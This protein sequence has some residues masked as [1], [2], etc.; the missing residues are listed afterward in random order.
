M[1]DT[2]ISV[3]GISDLVLA[4]WEIS[5]FLP[6]HPCQHDSLKHKSYNSLLK[7]LQWFPILIVIKFK[8]F[9]IVYMSC[10]PPTSPPSYPTSH[11]F[12]HYALTPLFILLLEYLNL[13]SDSGTLH[14]LFL[15]FSWHALPTCVI[16][17]QSFFIQTSAQ[18]F[19]PPKGCLL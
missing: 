15:L 1:W 6:M 10:P 17:T 7:I 2:V 3:E 18:M 9:L 11:P 14:M 16:V 19:V 4:S 12:T 8:I 5:L 13:I